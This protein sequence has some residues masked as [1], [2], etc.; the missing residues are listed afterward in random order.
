MHNSTN[1]GHFLR[2]KDKRRSVQFGAIAECHGISRAI[3]IVD[4]SSAGL[5]ID[6]VTGLAAGDRV[7]V[8]FTPDVTVEGKIAW[9]VWHKAGLHFT[10]P[11]KQEDPA[12]RFLMERAA[13][14]EQA[15]V[16]AIGMLAQRVSFNAPDN[17]PT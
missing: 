12:Y 13:F 6:K 9:L 17:D 11:L 5:R 2:R 10:Q 16:H 7:T 3:E 8:S 4:F 15:H 1:S 14:I